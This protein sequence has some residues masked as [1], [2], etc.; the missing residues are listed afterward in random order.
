MGNVPPAAGTRVEQSQ[1]QPGCHHGADEL[2]NPS[3]SSASPP[4][5]RG[6]AAAPRPYRPGI[7]SGWIRGESLSAAMGSFPLVTSNLF[8][9]GWN[10]KFGGFSPSPLH[11]V[12]SGRVPDSAG[13]QDPS[14]FLILRG[15]KA[16]Q[17]FLINRAKPPGRGAQRFLGDFPP[18]EPCAQQFLGDFPPPEP[19]AQQFWGDFS[20]PRTLC[21]AI[22]WGI[23]PRPK[24]VDDADETWAADGRIHGATVHGN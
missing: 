10:P 3:G 14:L 1:S 13:T 24:S 21:T 2:P 20:S 11:A 16:F 22:F 19:C 5:A 18:P 8:Q 9:K 12:T 7:G 4:P 17:R 15:E 23:F 6:P